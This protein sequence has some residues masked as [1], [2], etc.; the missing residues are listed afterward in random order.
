[1]GNNNSDINAPTFTNS[2]TNKVAPASEMKF[3][4]DCMLGRLCK[5][6]RV[7]GVDVELWSKERKTVREQ[8]DIIQHAR[9]EQRIIL[10][11]DRKLGNRQVH[12]FVRIYLLKTN[13]TRDQLEETVA[14]FSLSFSSEDF[15]SRCAKCNTKGFELIDK[16]EVRR[17]GEVKE[18]VL[19][20]MDEFFQCLNPGCRK[21]YWEGP[22]YETSW[23]NLKE[24]VSSSMSNDEME[25][26][27][28]KIGEMDEKKEEIREKERTER[29]KLYGEKIP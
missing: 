27:H 2:N 1:M 3:L 5:W 24:H 11:R 29:E 7:L 17:R 23:S 8:I 20:L 21:I 22:K 10:T 4:L 6:L 19:D 18:R 12:N 15:M 25:N 9:Q 26:D 28:E 14:T 16:E 13:T